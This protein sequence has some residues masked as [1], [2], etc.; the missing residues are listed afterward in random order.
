MQNAIAQAKVAAATLLDVE[1]PSTG[2]PW[3]WPDQA[4][5]RLQMAGI[6]TGYDQVVLR[7]EPASEQFSALYYRDGRLL[8]IDAVNAPH[9]YIAV[10]KLLD[11][12]CS[13]LADAAADTSVAL[14]EFVRAS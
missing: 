14:R 3:F 9:D 5:L 7:G 8:S 2:V 6:N 10:R 4:D 12:G 13:I 11:T 1:P